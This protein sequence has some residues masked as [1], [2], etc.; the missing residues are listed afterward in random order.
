MPKQNHISE[1]FTKCFEIAIDTTDTNITDTNIVSSNQK[2]NKKP[3]L[4]LSPTLIVDS[5]ST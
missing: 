4:I 5:P 2:F 1:I 3:I